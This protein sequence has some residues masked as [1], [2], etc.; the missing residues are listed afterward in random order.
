MDPVTVITGTMVP[1][2]RA[3]IDTDQIMPKQHLKKVERTGYG[4]VV[5]ED[6]RADPDFVLND[7]RYQG[8]N[9]LVAGP[10]F[11]T[12]SSREH[13][14]WG[15][16]QYGFEAVVAPSF[17]DIFRTNCAKNGLL[18]VELSTAACERLVDLATA[19]PSAPIRIDLPEQTLVAESVHERF[20]I[21]QHT[22]HMLVN[23]LD[24]I[25]L[26][27]QHD[28]DIGAYEARRP[29]RKPTTPARA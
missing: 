2:W 20:E 17:A 3:D 29:A 11:G 15:L 21:D 19:D 23:G 28:E 9:V 18:T 1:L 16:Q 27:L 24:P 8:G 10:N 6:W 25:A 26:T 7:P 5:F 22:K 14:P 12:G 4:E 13:A